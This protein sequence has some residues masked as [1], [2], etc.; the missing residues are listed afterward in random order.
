MK[1]YQ[2]LCEINCMVLLLIFECMIKYITTVTLPLRGFTASVTLSLRDC[3]PKVT[4]Y[5]NTVYV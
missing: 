1:L 2:S 5:E 3:T 4:S